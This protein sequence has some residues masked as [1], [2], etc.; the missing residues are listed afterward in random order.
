MGVDIPPDHFRECLF[1]NIHCPEPFMGE[2]EGFNW[3]SS[4]YFPSKLLFHMP[5]MLSSWPN[6]TDFYP[7]LSSKNYLQFSR[8][9]LAFFPSFQCRI[10]PMI[11]SE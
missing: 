2:M 7:H 3:V 1:S 4:A 8:A 6:I 11:I 9:C 5:K 10:S